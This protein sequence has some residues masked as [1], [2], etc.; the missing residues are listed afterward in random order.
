MIMPNEIT[1]YDTLVQ[2]RTILIEDDAPRLLQERYFPT[3][4]PLD[5]T[6]A[7]EKILLDFDEGDFR[8]G[9]YV[10]CGYKD[11]NVMSFYSKAVD[12]P[13][14]A[15]QDGLICCD[16]DR[17]IFESLC[18]EQGVLTPNHADALTDMLIIKSK[19]CLRRCSR[20]L[21]KLIATVLMDNGISF[22]CDTSPTDT[23]QVSIDIEYY[24]N[25]NDQ[26]FNPA[27]NWGSEGAT[28]YKDVCAMI[29]DLKNH[30]GKA[31]DLL[32]NEKAWD[33]LLSDMK[34]TIGLENQIHYT[35]IANGDTKDLFNPQI[36]DAE[37]I[38]RA[39]FNGHGLNI[40]VYN[41]AYE[42]SNG[43]MQQYLGDDT[44]ACVLAPK[45]GHTICGGVVLPSA[46]AMVSG[47]L[48]SAVDLK[49]G[50]YIISQFFD[51]NDNQVKV[52]CESRP[53]PAPLSKWKFITYR[54]NA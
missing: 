16:H 22:T 4:T 1:V 21:E 40:I 5:L 20:S 39:L 18:R 10:R 29:R 2:G 44:F 8:E 19:R 53:L 50:R 37:W 54:D 30:G 42:D 49:T 34:S 32:L 28:P 23:T 43:V 38:G 15:I 51:F 48:E 9:F 11:G 33:L 41:G 47:Q 13:R 17:K 36:E 52:R 45:C 27:V 46:A 3:E 6:D 24:N 12:V 14:V 7:R 35:T 26:V 25:T 31:D